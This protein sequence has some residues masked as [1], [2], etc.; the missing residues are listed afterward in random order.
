V[1]VA[2]RFPPLAGL[3]V[4]VVAVSTSAI[5]VD[6]S[7]APS[8]VKALYRVTFTVLLLAPVALT[9][10]R[11][12]FARLHRRDAVAA[13]LAGVALAVHFA[14]WFRAIELTSIAASV[15]LVQAHPVFVAL[16]AWAFL[17]ERVTR[18]TVVGIVVAVLGMVAM[19]AGGLVGDVSAPAPL[20]GDAL[21][22]TGAIA[23][24]GYF[25]AGRSV[26]QRVPLVPYVVVVYTACAAALLALAL[27]E[28]LPLFAYPRRE[29]LLFL[30]MAVGPGLF[31]HTVLNWALGH[32]ESSVVSVSLLGEPVGASL[33]ALVLLDEVPTLATVLG[34]TVVLVGIAVTARSSETLGADDGAD[35]SESPERPR[36]A[37][38]ED[39]P[40]HAD[41][42]DVDVD[43]DGGRDVDD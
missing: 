21:A 7:D 19:S 11:A 29:W 40:L 6:Y 15:T 22:V 16:G 14:A 36:A 34:G 1:R 38:A 18:R 43:A 39:G 35:G 30:A 8:T 17:G 27:A 5:L 32:L 20:L 3:V 37:S 10:S 9:R 42:V 2:D 26:R 33:L 24:A 4:A 28:G 41:S 31:G 13:G 25:L 12:S 23:A